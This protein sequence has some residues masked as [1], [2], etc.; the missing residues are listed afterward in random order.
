MNKRSYVLRKGLALFVSVYLSNTMLLEHIQ[1]L[2]V[3]TE[4][5]HRQVFVLTW[6]S[7]PMRL[8]LWSLVREGCDES[9]LIGY[10]GY[11]L[12]KPCIGNPG[13]TQTDQSTVHISG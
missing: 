2:F 10:P 1:P 4:C 5:V 7:S 11:P 6:S 9:A 13:A 3:A 12:G 8:C